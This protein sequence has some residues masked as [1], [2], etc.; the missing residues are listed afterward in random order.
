MSRLIRVELLKLRTVRT[1]YGL[2]AAEALLTASLA[3]GHASLAGRGGL[4]SPSTLTSVVTVTG[5]AMLFAMVMGVIAA[6]GEFRHSTATFTYLA[7]PRRSR[8]LAAKAAAAVVVGAIFGLTGAVV[9]TAVGFG[10]AAGAG[11]PIKLSAATLVRDELGAVLGAALLAPLG[12]AVGSLIRSEIAGIVGILV[13]SLVIEP[14][15]G[16]LVT[17]VQPYLPYTAATTLAGAKPGTGP[18]GFSVTVSHGGVP[19]VPAAPLPFVA[20]IA[21]LGAFVVVV[22]MI[23]AGSSLRADIT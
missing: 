6:S 10:A 14:I 17:S 22:S 16:G 18:G 15:V 19:V 21:L 1:T 5:W 11:D 3:A 8:V 23:A 13:W 7:G 4:A 20:V 12:V 2:L 9:A